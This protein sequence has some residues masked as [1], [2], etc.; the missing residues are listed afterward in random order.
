MLMPTE[1]EIQ[2]AKEYAASMPNW[3][4]QGSIDAVDNILVIKLSD[5]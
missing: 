1:D 3:P 5:V 2:V 4:A